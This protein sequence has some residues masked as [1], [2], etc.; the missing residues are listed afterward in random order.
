MDVENHPDSDGAQVWLDGENELETMLEVYN[1]GD[2]SL[3][4]DLEKEYALKLMGQ[5]GLRTQEML[6]VCPEHLYE[7][8]T[9]EGTITKLKV[10]DGKGGKRRE[11][12][13]PN[14]LARDL[15]QYERA[16]SVAEDTPYVDRGRRTIQR[17]MDRAGDHIAEETGNDNWALVSAHDLRRSWAQKLVDNGTVTSVVME[18]GGWDSYVTFREHYLGHISDNRIASEIDGGFE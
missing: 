18:L 4:D 5:C 3:D 14:T 13:V 6:D 15:R 1:G 9:D 7:V 12:V 10:P 8:E 16:Y 11:T 17:W 2:G